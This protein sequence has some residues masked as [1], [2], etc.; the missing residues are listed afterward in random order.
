MIAEYTKKK[1]PAFFKYAKDKPEEACEKKNG[2]VVN[3]LEDIIENKRM[4]FTAKDIGKFDYRLMMRD[5]RK[6][7]CRQ[8]VDLFI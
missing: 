4:C 1:V 5:K 2:S 3:M 7:F 6:R 8:R